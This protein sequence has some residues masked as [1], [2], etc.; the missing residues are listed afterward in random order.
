MHPLKP[1]E[2]A[3]ITSTENVANGGRLSFCFDASGTRRVRSRLSGD[4]VMRTPV[5]HLNS[6]L[7]LSWGVTAKFTTIQSPYHSVFPPFHSLFSTPISYDS[8]NKPC[9]MSPCPPAHDNANKSLK[10]A[11]I[12]LI[13]ENSHNVCS[14]YTDKNSPDIPDI[15]TSLVHGLDLKIYAILSSLQPL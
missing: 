14:R 1:A 5:H 13:C 9:E 15:I 7:K 6:R 2:Y 10:I 4:P 12:P 11:D 8:F 3:P